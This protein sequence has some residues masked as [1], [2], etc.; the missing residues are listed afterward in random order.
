MLES[1]YE[2][3]AK[4]L[5]DRASEVEDQEEASR[6]FKR[7]SSLYRKAAEKTGNREKASALNQLAEQLEREA[8]KALEMD[9]VPVQETGSSYF[10]SPPDV[11]FSD[12]GGMEDLKSQLRDQVVSQFQETEYRD[13]L[14][15]SP[16]NGVLLY[17]PPGTGKTLVSKAVC[18]ELGYPWAEVDTA[19]L[20]SKYVGESAEQAQRL[21]QEALEIQPCVVF[22][23]EIDAV[24]GHRGQGVKTD[25]E[26]QRVNQLLQSLDRVQGEDILVVA[27]TN[28]LEEV[29]SAIRRSGR[30]DEE[31]QVGLPDEAAR[32]KILRVH[33][34]D[35]EHCVRG[36]ELQELAEASDGFSGSD[37]EVCV[38]NAAQQAHIDSIEDDR[39]QPIKFQ[40]L[41]DAVRGF[42]GE[43][44]S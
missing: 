17:G 5:R 1:E 24:A 31:I 2:S 26:R 40:H 28:L 38:E 44:E 4:N 37:L 36:E 12:V 18:G 16:T 27:A 3:R 15:V 30:F 29:D 19:D 25:S 9:S 20:V 22:L 32:R 21:F 6:L 42:S 13:A 43:E 34:R 39:L 41:Q 10:S 8:D 35:R 7:S 14:G 23:D 11:D 33:L